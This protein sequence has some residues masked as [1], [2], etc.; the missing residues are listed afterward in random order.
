MFGQKIDPNERHTVLELLGRWSSAIARID[1]ATDAMRLTIA[2]QP[3]GM[4]SEE[5]E[6][7]RL[8]AL[9]VVGQVQKETTNPRFWP[10][11][12]DNNAVKIMLDLQMKLNESYAYQLNLL[13]LYKV[14]AEAFRSG[15]D[16]QAPSV[17]E[18]M[19]A[20]KSFARILDQMGAIAG[21]LARHYRVSAQEYQ[22]EFQ[23]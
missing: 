12:E 5:F 15:I 23:G 3:L 8:T 10:I 19:S 13:N 2:E 20:N 21:K 17:K 4:Q 11:L 1:S 6:K 18:I 9:A 22:R 16:S 14:A 7:A